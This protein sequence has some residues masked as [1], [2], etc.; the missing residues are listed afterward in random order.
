M[1]LL[2]LAAALAA[3]AV[4]LLFSVAAPY[5]VVALPAASAAVLLQRSLYV[6][7]SFGSMAII[8]SELSDIH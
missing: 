3:L 8:C 2:P 4:L 1:S 6:F 7:L 5:L